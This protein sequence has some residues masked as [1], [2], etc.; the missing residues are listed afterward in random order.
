MPSKEIIR[1]FYVPTDGH[2]GESFNIWKAGQDSGDN[3]I[4]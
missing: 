4:T 1:F 3:A 2:S